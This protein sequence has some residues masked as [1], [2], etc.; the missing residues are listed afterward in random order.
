METNHR[1]PLEVIQQAVR[2]IVA[3]HRTTVQQLSELIRVQGSTT[4]QLHMVSEAMREV[5]ALFRGMTSAQERVNEILTAVAG[6]LGQMAEVDAAIRQAVV[7]LAEHF[8]QVSGQLAG[9]NVLLR[10]LLREQERMALSALAREVDRRVPSLFCRQL[11][12]LRWGVPG[13][14]FDELELSEPALEVWLSAELAVSGLPRGEGASLPLWVLVWVVPQLTEP[15]IVDVLQR[16]ERLREE[17]PRV[18]PAI[19]PLE[20]ELAAD[21]AVERGIMVLT[22]SAVRGWESA[23]ARW[24]RDQS[25]T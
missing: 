24:Y 22:E 11:A 10:Q 23:V 14:F 13:T 7:A 12:R 5:G 3:L 15:V 18:I 8:E 16:L 6:Q 21:A 2:D 4:D 1:S 9:V 17:L 20:C 19:A 25:P